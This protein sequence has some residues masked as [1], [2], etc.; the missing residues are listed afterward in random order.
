M[1]ARIKGL[2]LPL[3]VVLFGILAMNL[4]RQLYLSAMDGKNLL[5]RH[6]PLETGLLVL[7]AAVVGFVLAAL[8]K[9]S[10]SGRFE[11]R[12]A[13]GTLAALG[14]TVMAAAILY[15]VLI[16]VPYIRGGLETVWRWL[17]L[18]AP[19]CL[20]LAGSARL[21]G[22]RPFFLLH[23]V[24]SLFLL[25][26]GVKCY[27]VWSGNPQ[28]QDY[29]FALLGLL[30]LVLF[31]YHTAAFEAEC[32]SC[33]K[34]RFFGLAAVYLCLAELGWTGEPILYL[35]GAVWALTGLCGNGRE[36]D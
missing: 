9:D 29:L 7:T 11:D 20:L 19:F 1:K 27:Q 10:G 2:F 16:P 3:A 6:S 8:R 31:S 32:G 33:R 25:L 22:Q 14:H 12:Y 13:F 34:T 35:G 21:F 18:V 26:H 4:R 23:V 36:K 5:M 17:G 30:A 24:P 28:M 15:T